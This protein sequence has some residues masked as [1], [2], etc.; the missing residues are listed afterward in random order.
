M[1]GKS[2]ALLGAMVGLLLLV[3]GTGTKHPNL[4]LAGD[5]F[6][7]ASLI[8]GGL[9]DEENTPLKIAM[10]AV[11]GLFAIAA[12]SSGFSLGSLLTGLGR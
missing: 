6:F 5:F 8:W 10:L 4:V 9:S 2:M 11:G 1:M 3:I 7:A 12:F